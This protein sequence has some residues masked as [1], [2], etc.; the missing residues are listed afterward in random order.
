MIK[1]PKLSSLQQV[2]T[3]AP[4]F[5]VHGVR[6]KNPLSKFAITNVMQ[7]QITFKLNN[8]RSMLFCTTTVSVP[9]GSLQITDKCAEVS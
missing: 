8:T 6:T 2:K 7:P 1:L 5:P 4:Q 9:E 3:V